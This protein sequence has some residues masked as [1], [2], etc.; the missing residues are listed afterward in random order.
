MEEENKKTSLQLPI[1]ELTAS[2]YV[3]WAKKVP[4]VLQQ[5][6]SLVDVVAYA[7]QGK[8]AVL[9]KFE[10]QSGNTAE[11]RELNKEKR[12]K[13]E[14]FEVACTAF[15][16][17]LENSMK[18][19][20]LRKLE[21]KQEYMNI[22]NDGR[23]RDYWNLLKET[24]V[25]ECVSAGHIAEADQELSRTRQKGNERFSEYAERFQDAVEALQLIGEQQS[26]KRSVKQFIDGIHPRYLRVRQR[27]LQMFVEGPEILQSSFD[28]IATIA[29]EQNRIQ[30]RAVPKENNFY[31]DKD[32]KTPI[33]AGAKTFNKKRALNKGESGNKRVRF[34]IQE[35]DDIKKGACFICNK[36]GHF[37]KDCPELKAGKADANK[38]KS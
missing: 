8:D 36:E 28:E 13:R 23:V 26:K 34:N 33:I 18:A 24:I 6:H 38:N 29:E 19:N 32:K 5:E 12:I 30:F 22:R 25:L 16:A 20:V 3:K 15:I 2:S 4:R 7:I 14:K 11:T 35:T 21:G 17:R 9:E 37:K 1:L 31:G 27:L 10:E